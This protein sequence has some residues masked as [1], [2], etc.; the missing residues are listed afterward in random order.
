MEMNKKELRAAKIALDWLLSPNKTFLIGSTKILVDGALRTEAHKVLSITFNQP[1]GLPISYA[2]W[3]MI[4]SCT[5]WSTER[6]LPTSAELLLSA[7]ECM[8]STV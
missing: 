2:R 6:A 5:W 4:F 7:Q 8:H 3:N 1:R